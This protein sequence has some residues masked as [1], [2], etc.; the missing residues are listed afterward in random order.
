M[1]LLNTK[2]RRSRFCLARQIHHVG[3]A[4]KIQKLMPLAAARIRQIH[5]SP[6]RAFSPLRVKV[7]QN[8]IHNNGKRDGVRCMVLYIGQPQGQIC[9]LARA[10]AEIFRG[11]G[12][13]LGG[14]DIQRLVLER[15]AYAEPAA[16]GNAGKYF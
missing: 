6:G 9:L 12:F 13:A 14:Q 16:T 3:L 10:S 2:E 7:D 4:S 15:S 5:K 11:K 8:F 1:S